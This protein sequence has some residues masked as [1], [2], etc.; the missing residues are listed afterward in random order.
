MTDM[1]EGEQRPILRQ[2]NEP[3]NHRKLFSIGVSSVSQGEYLM[4]FEDGDFSGER[5]ETKEKVTG[6]NCP[7]DEAPIS[8][9]HSLWNH[10]TAQET[11]NWFIQK[12]APIC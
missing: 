12:M 1:R 7:G 9:I 11:T 8:R 4:E 2:N 6:L 10:Y 3:R 5:R